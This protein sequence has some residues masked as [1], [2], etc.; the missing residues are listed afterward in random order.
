MRATRSDGFFT[1]GARE[2]EE[3]PNTNTIHSNLP[4]HGTL[5]TQSRKS[6]R[7]RGDE[8]QMSCGL[9]IWPKIDQIS[10]QCGHYTDIFCD[11]PDKHFLLLLGYGH[12]LGWPA[13]FDFSGFS[14]ERHHLH[15]Q[16]LNFQL[17]KTK[18]N[19][20]AHKIPPY[21]APLYCKLLSS[22]MNCRQQLLLPSALASKHQTRY[23]TPTHTTHHINHNFSRTHT[24]HDSTA[25]NTTR[26]I[27]QY[28][29]FLG[30]DG[31]LFD[32]AGASA[33]RFVRALSSIA[34]S[35]S[36]PTQ[37]TPLR[38]AR[39]MNGTCYRCWEVLKQ[40]QSSICEWE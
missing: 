33:S 7:G 16:S 35:Y 30:D 12:S 25:E 40:M 6:T 4:N 20:H 32:R 28:D 21:S 11:G 34:P 38:I 15:H 22:C 29:M 9:D 17:P 23:F 10:W 19:A 5:P 1:R 13:S 18:H 2:D 36:L 14:Q 39:V 8:T 24:V 3:L 37:D 31:K 27:R 26:A